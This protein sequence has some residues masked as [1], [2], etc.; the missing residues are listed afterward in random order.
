M[1]A[2][3]HFKVYHIFI[4]K[5]PTTSKIISQQSILHNFDSELFAKLFLKI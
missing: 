5:T 3:L 2:F 1:K 4:K